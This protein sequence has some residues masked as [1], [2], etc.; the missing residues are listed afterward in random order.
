MPVDV[1]PN[2][3]VELRKP[4]PCGT[5]A[6]RIY[7][8]GADIGLQCTGCGRRQLLARAKF[9]KAFKRKLDPKPYDDTR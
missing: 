4:H 1:F 7:R 6:W 2:E 5:N 8:V 9:D 3:I